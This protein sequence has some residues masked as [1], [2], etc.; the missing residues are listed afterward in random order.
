MPSLQVHDDALTLA[1]ASQRKVA[2]TIKQ[3]R[4]LGFVPHIGQFSMTDKKA[5]APH[6]PL[7]ELAEG[8]SESVLS[9]TI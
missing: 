2:K 1:F 7:H 9:K 3:A 8:A 4:Q 5:L 6:E